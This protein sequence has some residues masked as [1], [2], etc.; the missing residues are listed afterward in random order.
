[1]LSSFPFSCLSKP[2]TERHSV[3]GSSGRGMG[4]QLQ[5]LSSFKC[6][7]QGKNQVDL[8]L[9]LFIELTRGVEIA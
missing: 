3:N 6:T 8:E 4:K 7:E 5:D 9:A 1:M 2:G